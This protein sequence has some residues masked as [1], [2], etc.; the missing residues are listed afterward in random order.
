DYR[1]GQVLAYAGSAGFYEKQV[2]DPA[3]PGQNYFDPEYDALSSGIGR[4]PGSSFKPINYLIGI[5]DKALTAASLFMDVATDFGGGYTP[6]DADGFERG[7]VR[8]RE[9]LQYSLNIP[10]VKA[11]SITTVARVM[12]RA[13][14]FGLQFPPNSNPG[15]SVGIGTVEVHPADLVSAYGAIADSGTLVERRMIL[16]VADAAGN[17]GVPPAALTPKVTHPSTPQATYVMTSILAGNTDPA[18]NNWW[19]Q[20]QLTEGKA[21]RPA[22][23]K[24]GTSD[25]TEDLFA[26]GYVAPPA[27]ATAPA[28]VAGVWAGNSD[29]SPGHSVMSLELAAP[30]WHAFMQDVT[31]GTPVVDFTQPSGVTWATVD[32]NSGLVPGPYTTKTVKEVFIDGTVPQQVDNTKTAVDVDTVSNTLWTWDCPGVKDTKGLLDLSQVDAGNPNFQKYDQIWI[33]RARQGVN[34]RGGPNNGAT[35]YFYQT[36][37]WTPFGQTWGAPF[38]PT[39]TCTSNTGSPPPSAIPTDTPVPTPTPTPTATPTP[40]PTPTPKLTPTPTPKATPTPTPAATPPPTPTPT[41]TP[42][43]TPTPLAFVPFLPLVTL[44]RRLRS[45][46]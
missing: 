26:V 46:L 39:T 19:S 34:V 35:M 3:K 1:T 41:P 11:A 27:S 45:G 30:I 29:H 8:L 36:G 10:A 43:P 42:A 17:E 24:T 37:F 23:L 28:I 33:A 20:Y 44:T 12:Q 2:K 22:T 7:P 4:Q 9:A 25:Q 38:A 15:V 40:T 6:H 16:S 31:K 5:Q 14:D 21:R 18:Q 32:A 13:Q